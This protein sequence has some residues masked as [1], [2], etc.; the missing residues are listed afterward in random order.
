VIPANARFRKGRCRW[1][2]SGKCKLSWD[3]LAQMKG[4]D[5]ATAS[6]NVIAV[7][8]EKIGWANSKLTD[9]IKTAYAN[10]GVSYL[11]LRPYCEMMMKAAEIF[12]DADALLSPTDQHSLIAAALFG[13]SYACFIAAARLSLSGQLSET[14][15]L[16]RALLEN[17]LYAFYIANDPP[18]AAS[19]LDRHKDKSCEDQCK[20][21]FQIGRMLKVLE[22][23]APGLA[24][25][26]RKYYNAHIDRG[27]HPNERSVFPNLVPK[28]SQSG[29]AL[30]I[31][32]CDEGLMRASVCMIS[33]TAGLTF[34]ISSL[35][36]PTEFGQHNLHVKIRNLNDQTVVLRAETARRLRMACKGNGKRQKG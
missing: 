27:A 23:K 29:L 5:M 19:W 4:A 35:A 20:N 14:A 24:K 36:F 33:I 7:K 16:L 17:A 1:G 18:L 25:E 3:D 11:R 31:F 21:V 9:H 10:I 8:L 32:N 26:T 15:V 12:E 28:D 6:S 13:R 34:K 22:A 2:E 30:R